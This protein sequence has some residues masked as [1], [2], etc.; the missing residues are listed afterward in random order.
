M[1]CSN[2]A[3]LP[4]GISDDDTNLDFYLVAYD[5]IGGLACRRVGDTC[6]PLSTYS[7]VFWTSNNTFIESPLSPEEEYI[8]GSRIHLR[9]TL[10]ETNPDWHINIASNEPVSRIMYIN[11]S[12][13]LVIPNL[14]TYSREVE[15][16]I[17]QYTNGT[18]GFGFMRDSFIVDL[19]LISRDGRLLDA[20][21]TNGE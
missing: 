21:T 9:P 2:F 8:Y 5:D 13:D 16:R 17:W 18:F 11:S 14:S 4:Q 19:Q 20:V 10:S 1:Y 7:P 12:Y 3:V 6:T 15:G